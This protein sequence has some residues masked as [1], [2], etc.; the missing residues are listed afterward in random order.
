MT[1]SELSLFGQRDAD[2]YMRGKP[3]EKSLMQSRQ[4]QGVGSGF[5]P[6][7]LDRLLDDEP[8]VAIDNVDQRR[9]N[10]FLFKAALARDLECLLNTRCIDIEGITDHFPLAKKSVMAYGIQDLSSLTLLDPGHR[11]LLRDQIRKSIERF[12]PRLT[13]VRVVLETSHDHDRKLR[14]RVDAIL[15][16]HPAR[17]PVSFDAWLQLSSA[18]YK[19]SENH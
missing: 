16:I 8:A 13:R 17:P 15:R 7:I 1:K 10:V 5:V 18:Q 6:S 19:F 3:V 14:F 9:V 11:V 12:E 4:A 2:Q